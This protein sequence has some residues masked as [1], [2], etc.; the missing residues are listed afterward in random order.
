MAWG[1]S[2]VVSRRLDEIDERAQR[3][4]QETPAG[5]VKKR[6]REALPPRFKDGLKGTAVEMRAQPVLKKVDDP[7]TGDCR[8]DPK[9][10]RRTDLHEERAGSIDPHHLAVTLGL[11]PRPRAAGEAAAQAGVVEQIAWMLGS[12]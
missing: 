7:G 6:P 1:L 8:F 2:Q 12:V 10:G 9:I 3:C 11:P 4:G 5:I